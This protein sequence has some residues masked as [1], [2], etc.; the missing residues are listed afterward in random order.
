VTGPTRSDASGRNTERKVFDR[1][2]AALPPE[3]RLYPNVAWLGRTAAHRGLRDGEADLVVAHP[4]RGF[5]VIEVKSGRISRDAA[6]QWL[7]NGH[8][9]R[10]SPFEQ[11]RTSTHQLL[12]KLR[13]LPDAPVRW[14]AL[15][16]ATLWRSQTSI[17]R[18]SSTS[19]S[20]AR[21]SSL[22]SG[23]IVSP[24][25]RRAGMDPTGHR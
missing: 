21:M 25:P 17:S 6:G 10:M 3:Y 19:G 1:L 7:Q 15:S 13:E 14:K 5:L 24:L 9:L 2:R 18:A 23:S 8:E 12:E 22:S 16:Q 4:E 11:A 20:S